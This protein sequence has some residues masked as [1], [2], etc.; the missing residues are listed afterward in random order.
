MLKE[1]KKSSQRTVVLLG[2]IFLLSGL[3]IRLIFLEA[4]LQSDDAAYLS[5]ANRYSPALLD[6]AGNQL[7]F[8]TGMILP[9][10]LLQKLF[11]YSI[12]TYYTFSIF[13]YMLM[14]LSIYLVAVMVSG[15]TTGIIAISIA[16]SSALILNQ[17]SNVLPDVPNLAFM[18]GAFAL[19]MLLRGRDARIVPVL[20][21][22]S[23]M[24]GFIAYLFRMPNI[25][26][27]AC[28]PLYELLQYRSIRRSLLFALFFMIFVALEMLY[29]WIM[30]DEPLQRFAMVPRGA[31]SW[32]VYQPEI[33]STDYLLKPIANFTQWSTGWFLLFGGAIGFITALFKRN[34]ALV[35]LI[36]GATLVFILYSYSATSIEPIKRAL[37]LKTR[38]VLAFSV[39]MSMSTGYAVTLI[40]KQTRRIS[41]ATES[42]SFLTGA[43]ILVSILC[44]QLAELPQSTS[45]ILSG[46]DSYFIADRLLRDKIQ[47]ISTTDPVY[48]DRAW[49]YKLYPHFGKLNLKNLD[50]TTPP[51]NGQ[52]ILFSKR[53]M[54]MN[55]A[56]AIKRGDTKSVDSINNYLQGVNPHWKILLDAG[57]IVL[58]KVSIPELESRN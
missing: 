10:I 29:Y 25:V 23:A 5:I 3:V 4:P 34:W 24:V 28:I 9:L 7:P 17:T 32:A 35:A 55:R 8:R 39:V 44:A 56:Y 42:H 26:F 51:T 52:T 43:L 22:A 31:S 13:F 30:T 33:A 47:D 6:V 49:G 14:L 48:A 12:V 58:I 2:I 1:A 16:A 53:S 40:S 50:I 19:F 57:D 36:L 45:S 37:P 41:A 27:L 18:F 21:A 38:Y 54:Q 11:G 15:L 46:K 20:I